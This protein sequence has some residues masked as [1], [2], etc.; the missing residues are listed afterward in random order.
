MPSNKTLL[1][2][3]SVLLLGILG[4]L[5]VDHS[6]QQTL[7]ESIDEVAEEIS[8]EIDDHTTPR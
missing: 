4:L 2:I 5:Y 7:G 8:D 1:I 3:I 6:R